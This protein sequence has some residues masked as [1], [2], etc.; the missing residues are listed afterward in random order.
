M[1]KEARDAWG[2]LMFELEFMDAFFDKL[3]HLGP[4]LDQLR[5]GDFSRNLEKTYRFLR[6]TSA[7]IHDHANKTAWQGV[8]S[9]FDEKEKANTLTKIERTKSRMILDLNLLQT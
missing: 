2:E 7:K 5:D 8:M 9:P 6:E 3:R 1:S 4:E